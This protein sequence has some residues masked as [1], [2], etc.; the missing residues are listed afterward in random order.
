MQLKNK[1][2][3]FAII[4][5]CGVITTVMTYLALLL[6]RSDLAMIFSLPVSAHIRS[7]VMEQNRNVALGQDE[8]EWKRQT[9]QMSAVQNNPSKSCCQQ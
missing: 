3:S 6:S 9:G 7:L 5:K 1:I 8:D 4:L 2:A